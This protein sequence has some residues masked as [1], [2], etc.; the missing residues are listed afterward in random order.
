MNKFFKPSNYLRHA[1]LLVNRRLL[2]RLEARSRPASGTTLPFPPVFIVGPPR[3]GSTLLSQVLCDAFDIGYLS[4]RHCRF[5]GAP[6]LV[7][8][9]ASP[10]SRRRPSSYRSLDGSTSAPYEPSECPE[11]WYRFFRRRPA[12]VPLA[13]A[14]PEKMNQFRHSVGALIDT[15]EKPVLFKNL[16]ASLRLEPIIEHLPEALFVVVERNEL[17]NAHSILEGRYRR[18]GTYDTWWSVKPPGTEELIDQP[19]HAQVVGQIR[20]IHSLID[21]AL[22]ETETGRCRTLRIRYEDLCRDTSATA[23]LF[24]EFLT[25]NGTRMQKLFEIPKHFE[26]TEDVKIDPAIYSQLKTLTCDSG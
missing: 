10:S 24:D 8:R 2:A 25:S 6:F 1:E 9:L 13:D 21:D 12:Y 18:F 5:F 20:Q 19:P 17:N 7:E 14:D 26:Q 15:F 3:S 4:N 11:W 16:Y 23:R 22:G